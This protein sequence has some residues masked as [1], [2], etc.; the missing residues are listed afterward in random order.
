M[1]FLQIM[2]WITWLVNIHCS[3]NCEDIKFETGTLGDQEAYLLSVSVFYLSFAWTKTLLFRKKLICTRGQKRLQKGKNK[4]FK[5]KNASNR[6]K[7]RR[8]KGGITDLLDWWSWRWSETQANKNAVSSVGLSWYWWIWQT[9][10]RS[11]IPICGQKRLVSV[12]IFNCPGSSLLD[13]L[14]ADRLF[15]FSGRQAATLVAGLVQLKE[16]WK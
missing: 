13:T 12:V 3:T 15:R 11:G 8:E 6:V 1:T 5:W 14:Y 10:S 9:A 7:V 4:S 2:L 16:W